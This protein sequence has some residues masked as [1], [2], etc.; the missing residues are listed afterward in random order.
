MPI[1]NPKQEIS[2]KSC[3]KGTRRCTNGILS[4]YIGMTVGEY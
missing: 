4:K 2:T 1:I 3:T